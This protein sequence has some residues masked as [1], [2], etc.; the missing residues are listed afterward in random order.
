MPVVRCSYCRE[1][2]D[3]D[4]SIRDGLVSYCSIEHK[5]AKANKPVKATKALRRVSKKKSV[6]KSDFHDRIVAKDGY[7]CRFCNTN[8]DLHVH[9]VAY[10][11]EG[12]KD[13]DDNLLTLCGEHHNLGTVCVHADKD[14]WKPACQLVLWVRETT[15]NNMLTVPT[16]RKILDENT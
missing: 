2:V 7:R 14:K 8:Q 9:H 3:R 13:T 6:Q 12:G 1:Y 16:A 11:S 4:S 15:G 10:R 5:M